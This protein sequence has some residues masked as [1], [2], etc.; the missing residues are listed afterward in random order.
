M[1]MDAT[2]PNGT[3]DT[4][5]IEQMQAQVERHKAELAQSLRRAERTGA[6]LA[7]RLGHEFKP[8]L[9]GAVAVA[10]A[11]AAVAVTVALVRRGRRR[12]WLVAEQPSALANV[13]RTAGLWALR[14]VARRVAQEVAS[15]L[16]EP[17]PVAAPLPPPSRVSA[18]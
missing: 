16:G 4:D 6:E 15:R 2:T 10:G 13:A 18:R 11:A 12:H 8:A 17:A 3:T 14:L 5:E 1:A 7:Q 9:V